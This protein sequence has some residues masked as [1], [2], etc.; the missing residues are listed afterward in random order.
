[1]LE[2][3]GARRVVTRHRAADQADPV[4]IHITPRFKIVDRRAE[5]AFV[6]GNGRQTQH[7]DRPSLPR[8]VEQQNG[9]APGRHFLGAPEK[10][11]FRQ[12]VGA[13]RKDD[14]RRRSP[15]P[16]A[17]RRQEQSFEIFAVERDRDPFI[18]MR[19]AID[20]PVEALRCSVRTSATCADPY[21]PARV[22]RSGNR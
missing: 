12:G 7:A 15:S 4:V 6:I 19:C 10:L 1:M 3:D 18:G 20:A 22:R 9:R 8:P 17:S 14:H 5:H 11:F 13:G 16:V 2:T 21:P